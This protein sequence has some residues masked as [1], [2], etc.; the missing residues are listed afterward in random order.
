MNR[1]VPC[2]PCVRWRTSHHLTAMRRVLRVAAAVLMLAGCSVNTAT[3]APAARPTAI[4][5]L[6]PPS[7]PTASRPGTAVLSL[8]AIQRLDPRVGYIAGWTGTGV[9]LAKTG[10]AGTTWQRI[11]VPASHLSAL[12][13]IDERV[14]WAGGFALRDVPQIGCAQAAPAG[15]TRCRGVV[16]RTDD[17]GRTWQEVLSI[18]TDGVAGEPIRQLQAVDGQRAWVL[19]LAPPCSPGGCP[20]EVRRTTDGGRTWTTILHGGIVAIRFASAYRGWAALEDSRGDVE[21]RSTSD[22]GTTWAHGLRRG[23]NSFAMLDAATTQRAWLMT[24]DGSRCTSS[25]CLTYELFRTDDG[26]VTWSS[27]GNPKDSARAGCGAGYLTGPFFASPV[28][29][30]LTLSLGAGGVDV[31]PG[32][33]LRTEDGGRTW[34]CSSVPPNTSLASAA[35]PLHVWVTTDN[36][37]TQATTLYGS[38]DGGRTWHAL[39]LSTIQ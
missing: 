26:G 6:S 5:S 14:G 8:S 25:N 27:L 1:A 38:E 9:G 30:W 36:R 39:D 22:G 16:L 24:R 4:R 17:G 13:F 34:T 35:D 28:L 11:T 18:P 10:D 20:S 2:G 37:A 15:A 7:T 32:G 31:G 33:L 3:H 21:V 19:T 23:V 12:R 29:G